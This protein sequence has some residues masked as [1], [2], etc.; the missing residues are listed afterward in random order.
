VAADSGDRGSVESQAAGVVAVVGADAAADSD[1]RQAA[2][3]AVAAADAVA[4]ADASSSRGAR[5][6][7]DPHSSGPNNPQD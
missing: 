4:W 3:A 1:A 7:D 2:W 6:K 5:T